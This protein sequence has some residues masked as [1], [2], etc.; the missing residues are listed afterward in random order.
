MIGEKYGLLTVVEVASKGSKGV[1]YLCKC[2]CGNEKVVS[3]SRLKN[4][5]NKSCGC[6][7]TKHNMRG[8]RIY[9]CWQNMRNR[10][11]NP[12]NKRYNDYGGRGISVDPRWNN[13]IHF[14]EDMNEGYEEGLTLDRIDVNGNYCKENCRWADLKTQANNTRRN[15]KVLYKG[16]LINL[17]QAEE[18]S[19]VHRNLIYNRL[20]WGWDV[21]DAIETPH[22]A[23][24][25]I[26]YKGI[27][28]EVEEYAIE[29][30]M[31]YQ[32][33]KKRLMRGWDVERALT[34][35]LRKQ[36]KDS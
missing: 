17:Q 2:D 32:T 11:N 12:K 3:G 5:N 24:E 19:E 4:G 28:K 7:H 29:Y 9:S 22:F 8:T 6:L 26:N 25:T 21:K 30:G 15:P 20:R 13:F 27:E 34:Q 14:F 33:L 35:P 16:E 31:T 1:S 10:C 23:K 18:K 36:N